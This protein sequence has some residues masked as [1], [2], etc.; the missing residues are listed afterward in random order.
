MGKTIQWNGMATDNNLLGLKKRV[1]QRTRDNWTPTVMKLHL[2]LYTDQTDPFSL[3]EFQEIDR[4]KLRF[5]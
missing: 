2:K 3:A 5:T 1:E 4:R